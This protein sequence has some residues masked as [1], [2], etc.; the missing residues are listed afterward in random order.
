MEGDNYSASCEVSSKA[1]EPVN[2]KV[3]DTMIV[4]KYRFGDSLELVENN[5]PRDN[6]DFY[7]IEIKRVVTPKVSFEDKI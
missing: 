4:S 1:P 3:G 6:R 5:L 2:L 7:E